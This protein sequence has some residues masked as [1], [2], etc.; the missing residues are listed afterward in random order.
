MEY[1]YNEKQSRLHL[2]LDICYFVY[3]I[4]MCPHTLRHNPAWPR[5][6]IS[7]YSS[8]FRRTSKSSSWENIGRNDANLHEIIFY[9]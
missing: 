9:N 5:E 2:L 1:P 4:E 7:H 3:E 8:N 6:G